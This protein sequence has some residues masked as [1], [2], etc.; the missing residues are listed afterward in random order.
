MSSE[1]LTSWHLRLFDS[2]EMADVDRATD[3]DGRPFGE[4]V[5]T[6]GR[7]VAAAVRQYA[8]PTQ[9]IAVLA[10]PGNNGA[11]AR[12]A[13]ADLIEGGWSVEVYAV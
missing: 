5:A 11:D 9:R 6:A 1:R 4:L 8:Q 7:A 2:Q 10:G 13:A 3:R 12:V